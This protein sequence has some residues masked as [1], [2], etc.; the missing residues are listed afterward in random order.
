MNDQAVEFTV[1]ILYNSETIV[2]H[3]PRGLSRSFTALL[4]SGGNVTV[5]II[6]DSFK[7]M[8]DGIC[9]PCTYIV[10]GKRTFVQDIKDNLYKMDVINNQKKSENENQ[11]EIIINKTSKPIVDVNEKCI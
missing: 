2:G 6:A 3:M 1:N 8:T 10:S 4:L 11:M 7:S 9:V 5:K